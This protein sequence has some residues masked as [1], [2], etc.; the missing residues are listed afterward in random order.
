MPI[1]TSSSDTG[2]TGAAKFVTS[3][4]GVRFLVPTLSFPFP[5]P[6]FPQLLTPFP[7]HR[8]P[9]VGS[10]AQLAAWPAQQAAGSATRSRA[11]RA[12]RANR[13]ATGLEM[14]PV[15]S[16]AGRRRSPRASRTRA[17]GRVVRRDFKD[18][19]GDDAGSC[20]E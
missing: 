19:D 7:P 9:S 14:R 20:N 8:T 5:I 10:H 18:G 15:A 12:L 1:N 3:T 2:V 4:V 17:S 6:Q 11:R 16:R 13:W